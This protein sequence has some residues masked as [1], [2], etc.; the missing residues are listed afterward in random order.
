M[1]DITVAIYKLKS[2]MSHCLFEKWVTLAHK[3]IF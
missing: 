2:Y 1:P 3:L